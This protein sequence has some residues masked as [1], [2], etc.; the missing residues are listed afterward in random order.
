MVTLQQVDCFIDKFKALSR[1]GGHVDLNLSS[2]GGG[3]VVML[4]LHLPKVFPQSRKYQ[5]QRTPVKP[6]EK[7]KND[8][9]PCKARR[10]AK[11]ALDCAKSVEAASSEASAGMVEAD[12]A[13]VSSP[14][15][16]A[17]STPV[18]PYSAE[19]VDIATTSAAVTAASPQPPSVPVRAAVMADPDDKVDTTQL[20]SAE[21]V[22]AT[23][24][25]S[26]MKDKP[27][28]VAEKVETPVMLP[29]S[30]EKVAITSQV[31]TKE[32]TALEKMQA[33]DWT[34]TEPTML[35][36]LQAV[37]GMNKKMENEDKDGKVT[38]R[39][40]FTGKE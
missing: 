10:K 31:L 40:V 38:A 2:R 34:P 4:S 1:E 26:M 17:I 8:E 5:N 30:A 37:Q 14:D 36:L 29:I 39:T 32:R 12:Q 24:K 33:S 11:R 6:K 18:L 35:Q 16:M 15:V 25:S 13:A 27:S 20:S 21:M 3:L 19:T 7:R 23:P 28:K 9:I 22:D